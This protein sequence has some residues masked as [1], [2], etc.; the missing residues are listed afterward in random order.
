MHLSLDQQF[1]LDKFSRI[2]DKA[3]TI[4]QLRAISKQMLKAWFV[5]RA[6]VNFVLKQK[7]IDL[8]E[9]TYPSTNEQ[10]PEGA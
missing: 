6:A 3:H 8:K 10:Q 5:Q 4:E 7:L 2:I 1:E 9:E